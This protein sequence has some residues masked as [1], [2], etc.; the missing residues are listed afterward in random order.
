MGG[1]GAC[2][3]LVGILDQAPV[4]RR[5][6]RPGW[7]NRQSSAPVLGWNQSRIPLATHLPK[8]LQ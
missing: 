7:D 6:R 1:G 4:C 2:A 5:L 3:A 8:M